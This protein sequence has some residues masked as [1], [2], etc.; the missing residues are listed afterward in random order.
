[1]TRLTG[2]LGFLALLLACAPRTDD[3]CLDR[4]NMDYPTLPLY[5]DGAEII[6]EASGIPYIVRVSEPQGDS[7]YGSWHKERIKEPTAPRAPDLGR[8]TDEYKG[9]V[10]EV[11]ARMTVSEDT[12]IGPGRVL[13]AGSEDARHNLLE[14]PEYSTS[15]PTSGPHLS[16]TWPCGFY[17]VDYTDPVTEQVGVPDRRIVHNLEHGHVVMSYNLPDQEDVER[18]QQV[19]LGL[20]DHGLWLISR[21][22]DKI[23]EG[24]VAMTAWGVL[25]VFDGVN[26]QR[27][28]AFY[29]AY[30]SNRFSGETQS[31]GRGIPC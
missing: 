15:P 21:P 17:N 1:M 30:K 10:G 25:D 9:G 27:I 26:E 18:L 14:W 24:T 11:Q 12:L 28:E 2:I 22:Y 31:A 13:P 7:L 16:F 3:D 19:H 29:D 23:E 6:D 4:I 5:C 8:G 20:S